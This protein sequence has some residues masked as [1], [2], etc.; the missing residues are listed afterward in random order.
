VLDWQAKE[1]AKLL[2]I[3][4]SVVHGL[5]RRARSTMASSYHQK[6][7]V[8]SIDNKDRSVLNQY[9]EAWES[10]DV[11]RLISLLANKV[12]LTMPPSPTWFSG[13]KAVAA[14]T[15]KMFMDRKY[16]NWQLRQTRANDQVAFAGYHLEDSDGLYHA[17]S[18][19]M[20]I[21]PSLFA[22]FGL[23]MVL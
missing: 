12:V 18:F 8:P 17:H 19:H 20:F 14:H 4:L 21:F 5:L 1:V 15:R 6:E 23:P 9:I 22:R 10:A 11:E 13:R 3:T 7:S 2:D 16:Q